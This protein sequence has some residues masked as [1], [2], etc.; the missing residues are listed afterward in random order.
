MAIEFEA[1]DDRDDG[2]AAHGH[3]HGG[4][5]GP[6]GRCAEGGDGGNCGATD[7]EDGDL[8][9]PSALRGAGQ[10]RARHDYHGPIY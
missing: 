6:P 3:E 4:A 2:A 10:G 9:V 8:G 5:E 7:T 1:V